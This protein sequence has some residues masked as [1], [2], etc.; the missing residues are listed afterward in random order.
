M[1]CNL[2]KQETPMFGAQVCLGLFAMSQAPGFMQQ[3]AQAPEVVKLVSWIRSNYESSNLNGKI[4]VLLADADVHIL[5]NHL[6]ATL[7]PNHTWS[8]DELVGRTSV[9]TNQGDAY[10]T[11]MILYALLKN[12]VQIPVVDEIYNSL[13]AIVS[14]Q[15]MTS[16]V[17][18][19]SLQGARVAHSLNNNFAMNQLFAADYATGYARLAIQTYQDLKRQQ[20]P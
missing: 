12:H 10:A 11:G 6:Q 17:H 13:V 20:Q 9:A 5:T 8:N 16:R 14:H 1:I 2:L 15:E 19:Q 18:S 3:H 4:M 7:K